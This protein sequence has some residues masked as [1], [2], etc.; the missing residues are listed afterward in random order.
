MPSRNSS[1]APSF[2]PEKPRELPRYFSELETLMT[3]ARVTEGQERKVL[4]VRYVPFED[5]QLWSGLPEYPAPST[6]EQFKAAVLKL[7]PG[8]T[9]ERVFTFADIDVIVGERLRLG[10]YTKEDLAAYHRQFLMIT[11]Y[12]ISL[13]RLSANEQGRAFMRGFST[14]VWHK[15]SQHLQL[16]LPDHFPEDPYAL[17]EI[18]EAANFVLGHAAVN[19]AAPLA[20]GTSPAPN[21]SPAQGGIKAEDLHSIFKKFAQTIAISMAATSRVQPQVPYQM[22]QANPRP[23]GSSRCNFCGGEGHFIAQ[24]ATV[25]QYM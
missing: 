16:K 6:F 3:A 2:D 14:E 10:I 19:S 12:L 20:A 1:S 4:A 18:M 11:Q 13:D 17:A 24:C 8:A 25:E 15:V 23:G 5:S 9:N 7:Y 21:A 22:T